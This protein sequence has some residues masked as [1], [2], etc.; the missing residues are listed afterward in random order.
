MGRDLL[1]K[2]TPLNPEGIDQETIDE[3]DDSESR[4]EQTCFADLH[5][6]FG[7][8]P[9]EDRLLLLCVKMIPVGEFAP[10]ALTNI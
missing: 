8:H 6:Q 1:A 9:L 5:S 2:V 10:T 3:D 4:H 7:Q